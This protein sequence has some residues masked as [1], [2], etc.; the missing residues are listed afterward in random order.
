MSRF[1]RV[2]GIAA[3]LGGALRI[4]DSFTAGPPATLALLYMATDVFLLAAIA[5]LWLARR[6]R[7]DGVWLGLAAL[8]LLMVRASAFGVGSYSAGATVTLIALALFAMNA[9]LTRSTAPWAPV[10]WIVALALGI[11]GTAGVAPATM[12]ALAGVAFG[13]GFVAAGLDMLY[14]APQSAH[15]ATSTVT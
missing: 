13:L 10:A 12:T 15:T 1:L 4:A 3:I 14:G 2:A 7:V 9:L 8:G 5:G 6:G 11:A